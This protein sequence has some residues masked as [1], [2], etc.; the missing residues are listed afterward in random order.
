VN[1]A[2]FGIVALFLVGLT[3]VLAAVMIGG[4][5]GRNAIDEDYES[6]RHPV[7]LD[8]EGDR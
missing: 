3:L 1:W 6:T 4:A 2:V 7:N 8:E 5:R